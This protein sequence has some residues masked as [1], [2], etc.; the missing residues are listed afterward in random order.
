MPTPSRRKPA[1]TIGMR[2]EGGK[3]REEKT[4]VL[5]VPRLH[6]DARVRLRMRLS[7]VTSYARSR[8][9]YART[10]ERVRQLE[11]GDAS[12]G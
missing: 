2:R 7:H 9:D 1:E 3:N 4:R 5:S 6:N 11:G 8:V 10:L 12:C